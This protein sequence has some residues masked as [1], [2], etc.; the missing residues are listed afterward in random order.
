M[1]RTA[2]NLGDNFM[3]PYSMTKTNCKYK[4]EYAFKSTGSVFTFSYFLP[5]LF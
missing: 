5:I 4:N 3:M 2:V 1:T